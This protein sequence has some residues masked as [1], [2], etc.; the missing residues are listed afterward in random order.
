MRIECGVLNI[1]CVYRVHQFVL[2]FNFSNA[3]WIEFRVLYRLRI[4]IYMLLVCLTIKI[5]YVCVKKKEQDRKSVSASEREKNLQRQQKRQHETTNE[6]IFI[7]KFDP[8]D[9]YY[10]CYRSKQTTVTHRHC[11]GHF[12]REFNWNKHSRIHNRHNKNFHA[13]KNVARNSN[14]NNWFEWPEKAKR[15]SEIKN[16]NFGLAKQNFIQISQS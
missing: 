11:G 4:Y 14:N 15:K 12:C 8:S 7:F 13:K 5:V 2:P 3:K 6:P 10:F 1:W 16:K 9:Y